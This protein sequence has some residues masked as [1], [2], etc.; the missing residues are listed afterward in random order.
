[1]KRISI[2]IAVIIMLSSTQTWA[3]KTQNFNFMPL[4]YKSLHLT[5]EQVSKIE[6]Q[7]DKTR[8]IKFTLEGTTYEGTVLNFGALVMK[9]PKRYWVITF[10]MDAFKRPTF[11]VPFKMD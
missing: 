4:I 11:I 6:I 2:L 5:G 1:M 8:Y 9:S 3:A 10:D 7:E